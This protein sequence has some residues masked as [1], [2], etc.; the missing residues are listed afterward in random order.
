MPGITH[1]SHMRD[2]RGLAQRGDR[3]G[4]KGA[5]Q[6]HA[7]VAVST[8]Y[9][10]LRA[11]VFA[12]W[13]L[14]VGL[15][16]GCASTPGGAR[17]GLG[18]TIDFVDVDGNRGT[19]EGLRGHLVILDVCASWATACNLNAKVLDEVAVAL[20]GERADIVT[21][22]VDE[23]DIGKV[24]LRSYVETL[25]VK[26]PV[27]LAGSRVRAGTSALGDAGYVPRLVVLDAEGR[28]VLDDSGGVISVEGL[29][30]RVR[31]FLPPRA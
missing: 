29:V 20:A 28:V 16:A 14:S 4:A 15:G 19:L 12:F 21:L 17:T 10:A 27:F 11:T 25:G 30:K 26:H 8:R 2:S 7:R 22:L 18:A 1:M 9:L 6:R 13:A 23:G 31:P 5:T 3:D 24:A